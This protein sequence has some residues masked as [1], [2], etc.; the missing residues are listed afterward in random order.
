MMR[1]YWLATSLLLCSLAQAELLAPPI[2][3]TVEQNYTTNPEQSLVKVSGQ[4]SKLPEPVTGDSGFQPSLMPSDLRVI[5]SD[6]QYTPSGLQPAAGVKVRFWQPDSPGI[7]YIAE[8]DAQGNYLIGL[9]EGAWLG[10]ACGSGIGFYPAAWQL[11]IVDEK[12]VSMQAITHKSIQLNSLQQDLFERYPQQTVTLTGSGF[13]CNGALLFTYSNAVDHCGNTQPVDY[14]QAVI[15]VSDFS[16]RSDTELR[17]LM[18]KLN[19]SS[20]AMKHIAS[21]HYEQGGISSQ[22]VVI[23]ERVLAQL[24]ASLCS[25]EDLTE[26][27]RVI[28]Q[29]NMTVPSDGVVAWRT[30][31]TTR[32]AQNSAG[33]KEITQEITPQDIGEDL[34]IRGMQGVGLG[35]RSTSGL[36]L[37]MKGLR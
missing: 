18:P 27:N 4:V 30:S 32:P 2:T 26:N 16:Y 36:R 9:G 37:N 34:T 35:S 7:Y 6:A 31:Q 29:G 28:F 21:V 14:G 24:P 1:G 12:L 8:T 10:E 20:S 3:L 5:G 19:P 11:S 25:G 33:I 23:G 15:R 17:F 13:G 22:G